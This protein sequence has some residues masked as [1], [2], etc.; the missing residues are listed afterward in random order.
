MRSRMDH[1]RRTLPARDLLHDPQGLSRSVGPGRV[2]GE[3]LVGDVRRRPRSRRVARPGIPVRTIAVSELG[4]QWRALARGRQVD[5]L[6]LMPRTVVRAP[7]R[8]EQVTRTQV[9]FGP[10]KERPWVVDHARR[11]RWIPKQAVE[12]F[13]EDRDPGAPVRRPRIRVSTSR[14]TGTARLAAAV[15]TYSATTGSS[16]RASSAARA[17]W[18]ADPRMWRTCVAFASGWRYAAAAASPAALAACRAA[19]VVASLAARWASAAAVR[20]RRERGAPSAKTRAAWRAPAGRGSSGWAFWKRTSA[21]SA[22]ATAY[23]AMAR[24]SSIVNSKS[25]ERVCTSS[26]FAQ[27]AGQPRAPSEKMWACAVRASESGS[28][29]HAVRQPRDR[30]GHSGA[31]HDGVVVVGTRDHHSLGQGGAWS[32]TRALSTGGTTESRSP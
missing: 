2:P 24:S 17:A 32:A 18:A 22:H 11:R 20:W 6:G 25:P 7:A 19:S 1:R 14:T 29:A 16:P 21:G 28:S 5:V 15:I 27:R 10:V 23:P 12:P 3:A 13:H 4:S 26:S 9:G 8:C 30:V 31:E